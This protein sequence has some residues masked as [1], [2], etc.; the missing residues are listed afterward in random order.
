MI[1]F[2]Q[3][4]FYWSNIC[5]HGKLYLLA[6][7]A[8]KGGCVLK[9]WPMAW[10]QKFGSSASV[11]FLKKEV[12]L[13]GRDSLFFFLPPGTWMRYLEL[14]WSKSSLPWG[15]KA[16]TK[17]PKQKYRSLKHRLHH[18]I[19]LLAMEYLF[20]YERKINFWLFFYQSF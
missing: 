12:D 6:F 10:R 14:Q 9:F 8:N 11:K 1:S 18:E 13:L 19:T 15:W 2:F 16:V 4:W 17:M 20:L 7:H 5:T 3:V